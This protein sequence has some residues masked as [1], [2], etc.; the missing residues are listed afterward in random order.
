MSNLLPQAI[1]S[2]ESAEAQ[3]CKELEPKLLDTNNHSDGTKMLIWVIGE[4]NLMIVELR[5][6]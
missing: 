6:L 4:L 5:N 2:L 3:L 1:A